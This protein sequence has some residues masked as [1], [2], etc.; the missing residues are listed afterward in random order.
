M[1]PYTAADILLDDFL[2]GLAV[3]TRAEETPRDPG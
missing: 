1:D 3:E 2:Q